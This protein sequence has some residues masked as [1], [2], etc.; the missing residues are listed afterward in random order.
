M[1]ERALRDGSHDFDFLFGSWRVHNRR[2]VERLRGSTEWEEFPSTCHARPI[3]GG[4]GN[5]DE[6]ALE[7]RSG[8]VLAITVRLYDPVSDE[9]SIYWSASPG[10][11]RFDVPMVGRFDEGRGEFYSQEVFE[12]RHIFSRF[13]WTVQGADS[14][15]WEQAYSA[16][17]ARTWETNWTME[18]IRTG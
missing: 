6:F 18:F 4:L 3:L 5:M 13:I 10:R 16:D 1:K 8:R 15:R 17:G 7:R 9:W 12:G 2:L 11:G 14:C